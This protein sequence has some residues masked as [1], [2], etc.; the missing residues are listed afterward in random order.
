MAYP[1]NVPGD[2]IVPGTLRLGGSISPTLAR[3]SVLAI[4]EEQQ[5]VIPWTWWR[6]HDALATNLPGTAATDDLALIGGTWASA[7]P[8]IQSVDFGG[9]STTAYARAQIPLPWE[10][11]DANTVKIRFH[12]G[13]L[14][15]IA[16]D[17]AKLDLVCYE[18]D[19]EVGISADICATAEQSV[20]SLTMADVD[21]TITA[22]SLVAGDLLDCRIKVTGNDATDLGDYITVVI[23]SV[24]LLCDVR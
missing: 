8:S 10:Y 9:T 13:M 2:L 23:G 21:F 4:A 1:T 11:E 5:F 3:S 22:T 6:V 15:T 7:S 12:V 14:S 17:Y 16:S 24:K 20:N 19:E 18:T